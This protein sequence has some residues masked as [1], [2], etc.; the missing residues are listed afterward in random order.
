M[1]E[2]R[3]ELLKLYPT[4]AGQ[5]L[6]NFLIRIL[7]GVPRTRIYRAI[8]KGEVRVN[9]SRAKQNQRLFA[10]DEIRIPPVRRSNG[11]EIKKN[12]SSAWGRSIEESVIFEDDRFLI[13]NKRSGVAVHGGSSI[14]CGMIESLR[15]IRPNA[16]YLELVH[17]LDRDTSGL[18]MVAKKSTVL[19]KLHH[20]L[21]KGEIDKRYLALVLGRWPAR[22]GNIS[23]PLEK[24][25]LRAGE[26]LVKV[27][28]NGK[29]SETKFR[30]LERFRGATLVEV[31]PVT[32]RTHQIRVHALH[33]GHPI[34]GDKKYGKEHTSV[35]EQQVPFKRLFLH[36]KTLKF[37]FDGEQIL[38]E[39]APDDEWSSACQNLRTHR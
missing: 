13:V 23:A 35:K 38:L 30:V 19:K 3:A 22:L 21:R 16:P 27:T 34:L 1:S 10:G 8:R 4:Q 14:K 39:A 24:F 29:P 7:K 18:V 17:R 37:K 12:I 36:A 9:A 32:G 5:R 28:A 20:L 31:K 26:R 11:H 25:S 6:D 15:Q 33:A 2:H